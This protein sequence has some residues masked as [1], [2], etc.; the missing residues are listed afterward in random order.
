MP[1][2]DSKSFGELYHVI[3]ASSRAT[4]TFHMLSISL[5]CLHMQSYAE[6]TVST[7][8]H[9]QIMPHQHAMLVSI[10]R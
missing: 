10:P 5:M 9:S 3:H 4:K 2:R 1:L 6:V 8:C 7:M